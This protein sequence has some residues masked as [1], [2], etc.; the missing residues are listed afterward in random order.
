MTV[1]DFDTRA[2]LVRSGKREF[3]EHGFEG[4]SLRKICA[5]AH[6]TTGAFYSNFKKKED[7][8]SAI[9]E[10]D[11]RSYNGVY[12]GL[13]DR[14]VGHVVD[15]EDFETLVMDFIM[16]HRDLFVLLF[17]CSKGTPYEGFKAEL[18]E[19]F[20]RTYQQF[21]DSYSATRVDPDVTRTI[22]RMKFA[23][24]CEMIYGD[25]DRE[26]VRMITHRLGDF[27]KAGFEAVLQVDFESPS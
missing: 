13:I 7:L 26:K 1:Y 23:Q 5:Q 18:L 27:T 16:D 22:V 11:L 6:V 25:Y 24:Y 10:D 17:D 20:D 4:A 9:V 21:F 8:F 12:D 14:V 19:K 3:L 2:A 15:D